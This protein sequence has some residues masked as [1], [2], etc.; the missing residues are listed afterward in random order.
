MFAVQ[1]AIVFRMH[2]S[3]REVSA[4]LLVSLIP[5][6]VLGPFAGALADRWNPRRTMIAS[7]GLR[8]ALV[9]LLAMVPAARTHGPL[10][11]MCAI[12]FAI[13]CVSAFFVPAQAV[14]LPSLVHREEMLAAGAWMQQ[15]VQ[16]ARIASPAAAGVLVARFGENACYA[17]DAASFVFSA[18]M[19]AEI[20]C[21][22][23]QTGTARGA[24]DLVCD[25]REGFRFL[26]AEAE[27]SFATLAMACGTFAAGC[28]STLAAVYVRDTLHAG[29]RVYGAI[30][31]LA[32]TGTLA[33]TLIIRKVAAGFSRA[34]LIAAGMGVIG[35]GIL[36]LAA[37]PGVPV[38]IAGAG[39]IG[40]GAAIALVAASTLLRERTPEGLRGRV[41]SVSTATMSAAQ[42]A[43]IV[44][45]GN[46]AA[47][48]GVRGVFALSAAMLLAQPACRCFRRGTIR[49]AP[50]ALLQNLR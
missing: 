37:F 48:L 46:L 25:V 3:A 16:V 10:L 30:G 31:S 32:A 9:L 22:A 44:L 1:S 6:V 23:P 20:P 28:Y 39:G 27:L 18:A 11:G 24:T 17:A 19:L 43:A 13:S 33:G 7:D 14:M 2:G 49:S 36:L 8:A 4:V 50:S 21:N 45:S 35:A 12:C 15:T 34:T 29:T 47:A 41:S 40:C 42:A 26:F 5:A 38:A